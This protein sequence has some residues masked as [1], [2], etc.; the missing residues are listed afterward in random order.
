MTSLGVYISNIQQKVSL[1]AH[2]KLLS[3]GKIF[4]MEIFGINIRHKYSKEIFPTYIR[5][6]ETIN[7][8]M[9]IKYSSHK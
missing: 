1:H 7:N 3:V 6:Y 5:C 4:Y 2:D 8:W 9:T